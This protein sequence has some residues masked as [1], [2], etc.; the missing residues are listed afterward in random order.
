[1]KDKQESKQSIKKKY[2]KILK[3]HPHISVLVM[4]VL[5]AE[6]GTL[7]FKTKRPFLSAV[8]NKENL[9]ITLHFYQF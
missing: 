8:F 1:M 3:K 2:K 4:Q 5:P 9:F 7:G 6:K